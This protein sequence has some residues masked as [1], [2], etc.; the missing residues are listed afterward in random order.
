MAA[1][2]STSS[3]QSSPASV[4]EQGATHACSIH[5]GEAHPPIGALASRQRPL[6]TLAWTSRACVPMRFATEYIRTFGRP[7][8]VPCHTRPTALSIARCIS[9][10]VDHQVGHETW[11]HEASGLVL[12]WLASTQPC[13]AQ[14]VRAC[15]WPCPLCLCVALSITQSRAS[16]ATGSA[17]RS[18]ELACRYGTKNSKFGR[19]LT[20]ELAVVSIASVL[21]VRP[22]NRAAS[23][24][25]LPVGLSQG[26]I[27][28]LLIL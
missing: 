5:V 4:S 23:C 12:A 10:Q 8:Q 15:A 26:S 25:A 11:V 18:L 14:L 1:C 7:N 9:H 6:C 19:S 22:L 21:L 17:S 20:Y 28:S 24:T 2:A 3:P 16:A 27:R 13:T